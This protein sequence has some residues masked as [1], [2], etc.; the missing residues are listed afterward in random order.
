MGILLSKNNKIQAEISMIKG[1]SLK[2]RLLIFI[3]CLLFA[4]LA[5]SIAPVLALDSPEDP[6]NPSIKNHIDYPEQIQ[7]ETTPTTKQN[8]LPFIAN[9]ITY[10]ES[11]GII[12]AIGDVQIQYDNRKL[13]ADEITYYEKQKYAVARGHVKLIDQQGNIVFADYMEL[14]QDFTDGFIDQ[15]KVLLSDNSRFAAVDAERYEGRYMRLNKG[16]YSPCDLCETDPQKPVFWQ[17]KSRTIVHDQENQDIYHYNSTLEVKGIPI[18]YVP[19]FSHPDPAVKRRSGFLVPSFAYGTDLGMVLRNYYYWDIAP[20]QDFTGELG[21][22]TKD[23]PF[24]GGEYRKRFTSG[25]INV[26][27]SYTYA[28]RYRGSEGHNKHNL[29]KKHRAHLFTTGEFDLNTNWRWGF[30]FNRVSDDAYLKNYQISRKDILQSDLYLER[31]D[32]KD[33]SRIAAYDFQD[34]RPATHDEHDPLIRHKD[35]PIVLPWLYNQYFSPDNVFLGGRFEIENEFF[36]IN[37]SPGADTNRLSAK[38]GWE[39]ADILPY[40]F[41]TKTNAMWRIDGYVFDKRDDTNPK[42]EF[43]QD[44]TRVRQFEQFDAQISYPLYQDLNLFGADHQ[45]TIEPIFGVSVA[46][47]V[48]QEDDLPNEDSKDFEFDYNNL[49]VEN[50][51]TGVDRLEGGH[52]LKY[53]IKTGIYNMNGGETSLYIGQSY[54]FRNDNTFRRHTGLEGHFSDYVGTFVFRPST[55]FDAD[56]DFRFDE[57]NFSPRMQNI[58]AS[59]GPKIF[60]PTIN[61]LYINQRNIDDERDVRKELNYGFVSNFGNG[62]SVSPTARRKF[63]KDGE[64]LQANLAITYENECFKFVALA[65][66]DMTKRSGVSRGES[67]YLQFFFKTLGSVETPKY[68]R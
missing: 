48:G 21:L 9:E 13:I 51:F 66:R 23:N 38:I 20:D 25:E 43:K 11:A 3:Y 10:D 63:G 37:R 16:V 15:V 17:V 1:L 61:F 33:Y 19:Y 22:I 56:Y 2:N 65:E 36:H 62:W 6:E 4:P 49:F 39:R 52:R 14:N 29:G 32:D 7:N 18:A 55:Y 46:P 57:K 53:G 35:D 40:G 26:Q 8:N 64:T 30:D 47:N 68:K 42:R 59:A 60:R 58:H 41:L 67:F 5:F 28:E 44:V 24:V 45:H 34:L 31:F 54:R 27:S 50:R 12:K